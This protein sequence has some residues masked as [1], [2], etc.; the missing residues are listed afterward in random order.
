MAVTNIVQFAGT[1]EGPKGAVTLLSPGCT[2]MLPGLVPP[3]WN[4]ETLTGVPPVGTTMS[5][6]PMLSRF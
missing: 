4:T 3:V 6:L 1:P 2:T 5:K